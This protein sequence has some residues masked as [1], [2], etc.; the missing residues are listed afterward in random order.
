MQKKITDISVQKKDKN[1]ANLYL[2]NAFYMGLNIETIVKNK[3]KVGDFV[4]KNELNKIAFESEK[5]T[6]FEK[7]VTYIEKSLKTKKQVAT[8]LSQKGYAE[9]VIDYCVEKLCSYHYV[10][11]T[12]YASLYVKTYSKKYGVY[13]IKNDLILKGIDKEI[14]D[15]ALKSIEDSNDVALGIAEKYLANKEKDIKNKQK[16]YKHLMSKGFTSEESLN[17]IKKVFLGE[18]YDI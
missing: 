15:E 5:I 9:S 17:A 13:K 1:R 7:A 8:Y 4:D 14:I 11:D 2:D 16:A 3:L 18:D 6:A 10:D 12:E